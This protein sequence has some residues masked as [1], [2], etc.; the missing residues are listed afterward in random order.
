M[1]FQDNSEE[2]TEGDESYVRADAE[3]AS[4][5]VVP[6]DVESNDNK[7]LEETKKDAL[8]NEVVDDVEEVS[9]EAGE[10]LVGSEREEGE[11]ELAIAAVDSATD[12][13]VETVENEEE[14]LDEVGSSEE[15]E[16]SMEV[17]D[18]AQED[19]GEEGEAEKEEAAQRE[20]KSSPKKVHFSDQVCFR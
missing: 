5:E 10:A 12:K 16:E 4:E 15:N 17:E 7:D 3:E 18:A 13:S 19:E 11:T 6:E 9:E 14:P 8:V 1:S 20:E 2:D